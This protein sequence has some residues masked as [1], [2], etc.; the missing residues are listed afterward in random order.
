MY[1]ILFAVVGYFL[2]RSFWGGLLGFIIGGGFDNYRR[3]QGA[4]QRANGGR[5]VSPEEMFQY[6]QQRST[7]NDVPTMLMALSAAVMKADGKVL[8]AELNFVKSFFN[9]QFG[10]QFSQQHLQTLKRFLDSDEIPLQ[11]ICNDI[12]LRMQPEVRVQLV[13]YMFGIA[14]ADGEV[15][16]SEV[17]VISRIADMLGISRQDFESVKNMFY[18]NVDSDYKVLGVE[19]DATDEE[20]KKAYRKM[21]I[22]FHPDKVSQM[23]EEYQKGAKEKFQKIQESYEAI[24]KR[25]GM[26]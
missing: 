22:K 16:P 1:S 12:K 6:Y 18:R 24:K 25:R 23:G 3:I 19:A 11:R 20:V 26:K 17:N 9:Q 2:T 21:A 14:K 10:P 15:S 7:S 4:A 13:H 8:K 5:R